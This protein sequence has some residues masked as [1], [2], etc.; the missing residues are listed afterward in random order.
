MMMSQRSMC[1]VELLYGTIWM[2]IGNQNSVCSGGQYVF[3]GSRS[4]TIWDGQ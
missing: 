1:C 4:C 3:F 2:G